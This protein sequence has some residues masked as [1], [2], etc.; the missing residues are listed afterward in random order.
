MKL[1]VASLLS[2]LSLSTPVLAQNAP[3]LV[4]HTHRPLNQ[5][6]VD[7]VA[8]VGTVESKSVVDGDLTIVMNFTQSDRDFVQRG[9]WMADVN[10]VRVIVPLDPSVYSTEREQGLAPVQQ[11][12]LAKLWTID[13]RVLNRGVRCYME[14]RGVACYFDE[15][16]RIQFYL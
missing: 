4:H 5:D 15:N 3:Y 2:L 6:D 11:P 8:S 16:D 1:V 13:G 9:G 7:T 10:E 12:G 14:N